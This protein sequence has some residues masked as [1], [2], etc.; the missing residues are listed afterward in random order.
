MIP[1]FELHVIPL[2]PIPIQVWGSFVALG[3]VAATA[4]L[5][6]TLKREGLEA[7]LAW[8]LAFVAMVGAIIGARLGHVFFYDWDFYRANL[9]E[10]GMIWK[11]GLSS[12]GG[13]IGGAGAALVWLRMKGAPL[14]RITDA[15]LAA[16]PLG[17]FIGRIGCFLIHDHP[18]T[19]TNSPFGVQFPGGARFDLGMIDGV[20]GLLVFAVAFPLHRAIGKKFPGVTTAVAVQLYAVLRFMADFLRAT[21]LPNSDPRIY[22]FTPAQ[23]A[24]GLLFLVGDYLI[25]RAVFAR[26]KRLATGG[27]QT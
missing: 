24:S 9:A 10:I 6:R 5:S 7:R 17:W 2:G 22:G 27:P 15:T 25:V 20:I 26:K 1:Y 16:L 21:D 11:G 13:F 18:G 3:I 19:L 12:Y 8:D 14:L 4:L 23:Y